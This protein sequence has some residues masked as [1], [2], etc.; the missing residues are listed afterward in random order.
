MLRTTKLFNVVIVLYNKPISEINAFNYLLDCMYVNQVTICD[1]SDIPEL[2]KANQEFDKSSIQYIDMGGNKGL[3]KAYNAALEV[4][5][6]RFICFFDDDTAFPETYFSKVFDHI[7]SECKSDIYLPM[8][9]SGDELLSPCENAGSRIKPI[10]KPYDFLSVDHISAINSGMVVKSS[11]FRKYRYCEWLFLDNVD[12]AFMDYARANNF[13]ITVMKDIILHQAFS[14]H[15]YDK[16][17]EKKRFCIWRKDNW[18][19]YMK[20]R[21]GKVLSAF[22]EELGRRRHLA[23]KYE[24]SS[25]Y[26]IR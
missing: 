1:N 26:F 11:V 2:K 20:C 17:G 10:K 15:A 23:I 13:S 5:T 6:S 14:R 24:D 7:S 18:N 21:R 9:F 25:F 12:H 22:R 19:Y 8:V 4:N 16:N 3:P